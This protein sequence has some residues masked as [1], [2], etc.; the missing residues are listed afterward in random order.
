M[1]ERSPPLVTIE[2]DVVLKEDC[3]DF[4]KV[5]IL[6]FKKDRKE[7]MVWW[8]GLIKLVG[9]QELVDQYFSTRALS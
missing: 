4:Y 2:F 9:A 8:Q 5:K 6:L 1:L 7:E 3:T